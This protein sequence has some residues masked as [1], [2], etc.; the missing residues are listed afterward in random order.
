MSHEANIQ[1]Q[2]AETV[3]LLQKKLGLRDK[4]L[5]ESVKRAKRRLPR[6]VYK[7]AL[8]LANAEK[9]AEHPRL[10]LI[11]DTPAL[12]KASEEVQ[13]HLNAINLADRRWGWFL[14]YLGSVALGFLVLSVAVLVVLNWRGFI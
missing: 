11:L 1:S 6:R 8:V 13:E 9:L 4:T 12:E 7:Q 14:S 2:I 3:L 5:S 10:R